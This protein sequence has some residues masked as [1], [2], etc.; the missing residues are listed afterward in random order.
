M[1]RLA[2]VL[3]A[4]ALT[5]C[6]PGRPA[7]GAE[8]QILAL[9]QALRQ[10]SPDVDPVEASGAAR[11]SYQAAYQLAYAYQITD[12]PLIHNAKVNAGRKPRGLCYHWAEDMQARLQAEGF[13][14]LDVARAIANSETLFLIEHSTA[15]LIPKGAKMEDGVV[16]DPWR[17]GGTLFWAPVIQDDRYNWLPRLQVLRDKGRIH[18][19]Q[20]TQ[21]SLAPPP[22]N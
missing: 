5:A 12:S 16:I 22:V 19:V 4:C 15:V 2:L 20:R 10:M 3:I 17:K 1:K 7:P 6:A 21:G 13:E 9:A 14:T 11:L 8:A 18:Y